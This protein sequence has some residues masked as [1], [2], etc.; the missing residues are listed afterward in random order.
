MTGDSFFQ[1]AAIQRCVVNGLLLSEKVMVTRGIWNRHDVMQE[2][3][4]K[5]CCCFCFVLFWCGAGKEGRVV[6][7][8]WY[9]SFIYLLG[10]VLLLFFFILFGGFFFVYAFVFVC[11]CLNY[12]NRY[13]KPSLQSAR[14]FNYVHI[15]TGHLE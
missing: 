10:A 8:W 3:E 1:K 12:S 5:V 9:V 4:A 15:Y 13:K 2:L 14:L 7:L 11:V 6:G